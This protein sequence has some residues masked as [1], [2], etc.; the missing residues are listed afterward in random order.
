MNTLPRN[1]RTG[2]G[3][4]G[5]ACSS[6]GTGVGSFFGDFSSQV[7]EG[8]VVSASPPIRGIGISPEPVAET[9]RLLTLI[10]MNHGGIL[11]I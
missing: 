5:G 10:P 1:S 4:P 8:S 2:V 7:R 3:D 11:P 6:P 9:T